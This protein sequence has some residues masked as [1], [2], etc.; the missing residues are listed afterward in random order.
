MAVTAMRIGELVLTGGAVGSPAEQVVGIAAALADQGAGLRDLCLLRAFY[1]VGDWEADALRAE[2]AGVLSSASGIALTLVPVACAGVGGGGLSIEAAAVTAPRLATVGNGPFVQGLR[3]GR[4][5]FLSGQSGAENASL[6]EESRSVMQAL[7]QTLARLGAGFGDV[8]RMNRWYHAEGT[9]EAWEPSARAT[10][11][12][13]TEP[14]P[15]ATAISLPVALPEGRS[16][17]IELMGMLGVDGRTLPKHHS[18]PEGLWDWPIHLP[19]KHGLACGGI[20]FVGG[21]VSL[22]ADARVID[23]DHLDRQVRRSL[24]CIDRVAAGLGRVGRTLHL[25][26]YYEVPEGGLAGADPGAA[27]LRDLGEGA[28]PAVLVGFA[29]LSYPQMRVEIEAMVALDG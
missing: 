26:V 3:Q 18:W 28:A 11:S 6:A 14:G 9:K 7:G 13:Y 16:I 21:Q 24:G 1:R 12:F 8:V 25:G 27:A 5:L 4:F 19:Y 10:A 2:L 17:Q 29:N 22:D 23:P 15:I 20:G